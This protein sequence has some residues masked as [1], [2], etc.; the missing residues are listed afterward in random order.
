[1]FRATAAPID[2]SEFETLA[3]ASVNVSDVPE[4]PEKIDCIPTKECKLTKN[5]QKLK[6]KFIEVQSDIVDQQD[7]LTIRLAEREAY[8]ARESKLMRE[9]IDSLNIKL[10]DAKAGLAQATKDQNEAEA[11]SHRQ[12]AQH[13]VSAA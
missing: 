5:C 1:M 7:E 10:R 11:G 9:Q 2:W 8:C 4:A 3:N 12:A 13:K 6:D